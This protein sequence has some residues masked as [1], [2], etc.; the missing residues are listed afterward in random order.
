MDRGKQGVAAAQARRMP[1]GKSD[2]C[3]CAAGGGAADD[4]E[5]IAAL[6]R[7]EGTRL[8]LRHEAG[9]AAV[10]RTGGWTHPSEDEPD[11]LQ[12]WFRVAGERQ[13]EQQA[14]RTRRQCHRIRH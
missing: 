6:E 1:N 11:V 4:C 2:L 13:N 10:Q 12:R 8:P 5:R 3:G 9:E 14:E 7:K